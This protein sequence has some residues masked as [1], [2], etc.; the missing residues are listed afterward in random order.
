MIVLT[1]SK[2]G[3]EVFLSANLFLVRNYSFFLLRNKTQFLPFQGSGEECNNFSQNSPL[4]EQSYRSSSGVQ[5]LKK[6]VALFCCYDSCVAEEWEIFLE[7]EW[8]LFLFR[9][10]YMFFPKN[11]P[12][13]M[14][15][16]RLIQLWFW[17]TI[18]DRQFQ[19]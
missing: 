15:W 9:E 5:A 8:G 18:T 17:T 2:K 12:F 3:V 13:Q 14:F 19:P 11:F 6:R 4:S 10:C 7:S 1:F 16:S